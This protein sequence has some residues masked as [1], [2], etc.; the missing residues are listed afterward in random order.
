MSY[1]PLT[2]IT[3]ITR[4][5]RRWPEIP[6]ETVELPTPP[7]L[8]APPS[9]SW[10]IFW[11]LY[12]LFLC[13]GILLS[14]YLLPKVDFVVLCAL[15]S[16]LLMLAL[17]VLVCLHSLINR[18]SIQQA[19]NSYQQDLRKV[20]KR[21]QV[22]HWQERQAR[23][24][25]SPPLS[26]S[27]PLPTAYEH[28]TITPILKRSFDDQ[29]L[30]LWARRP[31]DA[32]FLS[33]SF[34]LGRRPT[35]FRIQELPGGLTGP[36]TDLA[37]SVQE[38][39]NSYSS[40]CIPLT[41]T[42]YKRGPV[43]I[44][45]SQQTLQRARAVMQS[46]VAQLAYHHSPQD[47]RIILLA[48]QTQNL[49]WQWMR[50]L[51]HTLLF[52]S[53]DGYEATTETQQTRTIALGTYAINEQLTLLARELSRRELLLHDSSSQASAFAASDRSARLPHLVI[54]VDYFDAEEEASTG[55]YPGR[56]LSPRIPTQAG[57]SPLQRPELIRAL[58][59]GSHLGV[60]VLCISA[61]QQTLPENSSAI[62]QLNDFSGMELTETTPLPVMTKHGPK[63]GVQNTQTSTA[64]QVAQREAIF[65]ELQADPP[66]PLVCER[67]EV[68]SAA[69]LHEFARRIQCLRALPDRRPGL[70]AQVDVRTLF[71]PALELAGNQQLLRWHDPAFR[72]PSFTG[73]IN[74]LLRI[75]IGM[76]NG[77]E[78]QYLDLL[79]DG[80]HGLLV[81]QAGSGKNE[82]LQ[83]LLL[84]LTL[85]YRPSELLLLLIDQGTGLVLS[86]F[87][88]LP[89]TLSY[90]G[91][92]P[93][94]ALVQRFLTMLHAEI[95]GR[96]GRL[97]E[98]K[99]FP[100]L[101][102]LVNECLALTK[103]GETLLDEL[104]MPGIASRELA[105]HLLFTTAS[106]FSRDGDGEHVSRHYRQIRELVHYS[107]CLRCATTEESRA[108]IYR[109]D[110]A[111]L[112]ASLPGRGYL[113]HSDN[114]LDLF[115]GAH[116]PQHIVQESARLIPQL[117]PSTDKTVAT[118][119]NS[120]VMEA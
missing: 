94:P 86:P 116:I 62:L 90:L 67:L 35:S 55:L 81:G 108:V 119:I 54:I 103:Q 52:D 59:D 8:T 18:T 101:L 38:L 106:P 47:V 92:D 49:A 48:P 44:L 72:A 60:S 75:P 42:L 83:A 73:K 22:L 91:P 2:I 109:D 70:R 58:Y 78:L 112:P 10:A 68:Y 11:S 85:A 98:G 69:I 104:Q 15:G 45:G 39:H 74:P 95:A 113:L 13:I 63:Q 28:L 61:D 20:E 51:P 23:M 107:L 6:K 31:E 1:Q 71:L 99:G 117:E 27:S 111:F 93:S 110:A 65:Y 64:N 41:T 84:S 66:A 87:R 17:F 9:F 4:K 7:V 56:M 100:R 36:F 105:V 37:A 26:L 53:S 19:R 102:I 30:Q 57:V 43:A 50:A 114:Q 118:S 115:Q 21:L 79:K 16:G 40:L 77:D 97:R 88:T 33:L 46:L 32:D 29:D 96:E 76:K 24:E 3:T 82:L 89:H 34:G 80:P 12:G 120:S 25:L 5:V 14:R